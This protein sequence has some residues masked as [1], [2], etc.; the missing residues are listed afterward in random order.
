MYTNVL[1][2]EAHYTGAINVIIAQFSEKLPPSLPSLLVLEF[3][4]L[5]DLALAT[6]FLRAASEKYRVSL[7]AKPVAFE[8]QQTLWPE[9][10]V[11]PFVAPWTAFRN[12][13]ALHRWPWASLANATWLLRAQAFDCAVSARWDPR[14]H[15]FMML[16][17]AR[18]RIGFGR[19]GSVKLLTRNLPHPD[20]HRHRAEDWKAVADA[21][22]L[23]AL[24]TPSLRALS[25]LPRVLV[26]SGAAQILRV[27]PLPRYAELVVRLRSQGCSVT[28]ACDQMQRDWWLEH[29]EEGVQTPGSVADLLM[30]VRQSDLFIGN[31]SGPGHVAA[32]FGVPTFTIFGNNLPELFAPQHLQSRWV[33]GKPCPYKPCF[34]QCRFSAPHCIDDLSFNDVWSELDNFLAVHTDR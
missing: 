16:A 2:F 14:D 11:V 25:I 32:A 34:D 1:F 27:W 4:G 15:A 30:L 22:G 10:R 3:W 21:L 13:Y 8:L 29:S 19:L 12:K 9:V 31:D 7:V 33:A 24:G 5:G 18:E 17:G 20:W 28:V 6:P 26:H 23:A